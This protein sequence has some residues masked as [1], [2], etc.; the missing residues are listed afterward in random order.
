MSGEE[1]GDNDMEYSP[2]ADSDDDEETIEKEEKG[3]ENEI[4]E[5]ENEAEV[6]IE[7]LLKKYYP[8]Q[9]GSIEVQKKSEEIKT[10]TD[11]DKQNIESTINEDDKSEDV[12]RGRRRKKP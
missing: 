10:E 12:G 5:L 7:E 8:D 2:D 1:E 4:N 9:F 6:P 3:N 11:D